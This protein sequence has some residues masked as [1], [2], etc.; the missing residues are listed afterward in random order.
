MLFKESILKVLILIF[1]FF[2]SLEKNLFCMDKLEA[3]SA[4]IVHVDLG[5]EGLSDENLCGICLEPLQN[6]YTL[7]TRKKFDGDNFS[8]VCGHVFCKECLC[9]YVAS[10]HSRQIV[11]PVC[12]MAL[13]EKDKRAL[14]LDVLYVP[15]DET[16]LELNKALLNVA[17]IDDLGAVRE[18]VE[19]GA[20][21]WYQEN[22]YSP[23]HYA[24][25]SGSFEGV[26]ALIESIPERDV[27]E[28][29]TLNKNK[30]QETA[31][32]CAV[33]NGHE[34]SSEILLRALPVSSR[35]GYLA[36]FRDCYHNTVL[37]VV[38]ET[39]YPYLIEVLI[40]EIQESDRLRCL[41]APGRW[42]LNILH[43]AV[44]SGDYVMS[45]RLFDFLPIDQHFTYVNIPVVCQFNIPDD[46]KTPIRLLRERHK[47]DLA[48]IL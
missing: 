26:A 9:R 3:A 14:G 1:I 48:T 6:P 37:H 46:G 2:A 23:L 4:E 33:R 31:L 38:F 44:S 18:F 40:K 34:K 42:G 15:D 5:R 11:C 13:L 47:D 29:L 41:R 7:P 25:G 30:E 39:R 35:A 21:V 16:Q 28:Y 20:N 32:F 17:K 36:D 27:E 22:G 12:R 19:H 8:S 10:I 45:R 24:V 43:L